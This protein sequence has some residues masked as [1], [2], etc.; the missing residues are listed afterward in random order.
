[1]FVYYSAH[2]SSCQQ[3]WHPFEQEFWGLL[4]T[5]RDMIKHLG[6]IPAIIHTDHA[7][8]ARV[9]GLPLERVE[10]KH[11]RWNSELRQGGSRLL[12]RP[13]IGTLHKGPDGISRHPEGRD[14]LILAR[15]SEWE[16]FRNIIRGVDDGIEAGKF[17]D[18]D[19]VTVEISSVPEEAL[20]P[21]PYS[22]LKAAGVLEEPAKQ[23]IKEAV[24][25]AKARARE[26][27]GVAAIRQSGK[28]RLSGRPPELVSSQRPLT[29][30]LESSSLRGNWRSASSSMLEA[31]DSFWKEYG[32][33]KEAA[34]GQFLDP[35]KAMSPLDPKRPVA[36]QDR[37]RP[38][39]VSGAAGRARRMH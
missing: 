7:N 2:L 18:D 35:V 33:S 31:L 9:E 19:P 10:A 32:S 23:A 37:A 25:K 12:H 3:R 36:G 17:D 30:L 15:T 38:M 34:N 28:W 6:R 27:D 11:F 20:L 8:I 16:K 24:A 39:P 4:S 22:E 21:V 13:G 14:R 5:R 26:A 29:G 1:M